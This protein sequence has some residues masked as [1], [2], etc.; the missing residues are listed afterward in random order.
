MV[1]GLPEETV[2]ES[3]QGR[4]VVEVACLLPAEDIVEAGSFASWVRRNPETFRESPFW[5]EGFCTLA[6]P[7][8]RI[9]I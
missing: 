2:A 8:C 6:Y 9:V 3:A 5:G 7:S 4:V 1:Y